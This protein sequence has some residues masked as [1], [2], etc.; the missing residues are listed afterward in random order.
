MYLEILYGSPYLITR[1]QRFPFI[2]ALDHGSSS[3]FAGTNLRETDNYTA[4]FPELFPSHHI[5]ILH[6]AP[7]TILQY[8]LIVGL[9]TP[10]TSPGTNYIHP[11]PEE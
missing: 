9:T 11:S 5:S 1:S 7:Q 8:S 3:A 4:E 10:V 2:L 6:Q